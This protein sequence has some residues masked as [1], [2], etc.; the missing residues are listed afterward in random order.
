MTKKIKWRLGTLPTP[1]ELRGL[2][3]DKIISKDEAR[4]ILF[5]EV[6]EGGRDIKS[7]ESEITFLRELVERLSKDKTKIIET[8]RIVE[9]PYIQYPW[10]Q[11]YSYWAYGPYVT[12]TGTAAPNMAY[13]MNGTTMASGSNSLNAVSAMNLVAGA[14]ATTNASQT[15]STNGISFKD[16]KTF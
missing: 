14:Q 16:I 5:N 8:I 13:A 2:I 1:E 15:G 9:R 6:E 12:A 3:S 7:L 11:P 4:E 10:F